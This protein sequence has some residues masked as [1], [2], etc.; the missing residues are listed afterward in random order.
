MCLLVCEVHVL[1]PDAASP[2]LFILVIFCKG[3]RVGA[4]STVLPHLIV[5][6]L[7][8]VRG[9]LGDGMMPMIRRLT[10]ICNNTAEQVKEMKLLLNPQDQE[11]LLTPKMLLCQNSGLFFKYCSTA[12]H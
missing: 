11:L 12:T 8:A 7:P 4:S 5:L 3:L 2:L 10:V 9:E 6:F 1:T